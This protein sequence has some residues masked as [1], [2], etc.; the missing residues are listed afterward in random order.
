MVVGAAAPARAAGPDADDI[1]ELLR[2][3]AGATCLGAEALAEQV[4]QWLHDSPIADD[5]EIA[6]VGSPTDPRVVRIRVLQDGRV[7]AHRAFEPGPARCSHLQAAVGLAIALSLKASLVEELGEPLPDDPASR[8]RG[9]ALAVGSLG[10]YRVLPEL[11]PGLSVAAR[12]AVGEHVLLRLGLVGVATFDVRLDE[13]RGSFDAALPAARVDACARSRLAGPMHGS[14]C[15]GLL[16]GALYVRGADVPTP[17]SETVAVIA[18][19]NA[20]E[21][22]L[23]LSER[24]SLSLELTM[25]FLLHRVEVGLQDAQGTRVGTRGLPS[26][27]YGLGVGPVCYF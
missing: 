16:G 13:R 9:W 17:T 8:S 12:Y 25:T 6:V 3:Q 19:A 18:F 11:A 27:G 1:R 5:V 15:V 21:L 20:A 2:V 14:A 26:P 4:Q 23:E 22:E 7:I 24:W 10:T